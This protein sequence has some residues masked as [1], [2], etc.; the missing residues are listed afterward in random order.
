M[1][2]RGVGSNEHEMI[3]LPRRVSE[4]NRDMHGTRQVCGHQTVSGPTGG[5][6]LGPSRL[7][8]PVSGYGRSHTDHIV[9][10]QRVRQHLLPR[11]Y[12]GRRP[13]LP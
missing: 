5:S 11:N 8:T 1:P 12:P 6:D 7:M 3:D 4:P 13:L 10:S 2:G 9:L